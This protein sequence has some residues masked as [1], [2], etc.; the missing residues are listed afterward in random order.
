MSWKPVNGTENVMIMQV[1]PFRCKDEDNDAWQE[2]V[3]LVC[4]ACLATTLQKSDYTAVDQK[5]T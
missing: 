4:R 5:C 3:G 2:I 1:V